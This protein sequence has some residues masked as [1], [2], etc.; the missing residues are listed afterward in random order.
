MNK[1]KKTISDDN[2]DGY[3]IVESILMDSMDDDDKNVNDGYSI[4]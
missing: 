3:N 4:E 1:N 2:D